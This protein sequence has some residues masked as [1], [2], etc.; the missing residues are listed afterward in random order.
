MLRL[1]EGEVSKSVFGYSIDT[2]LTLYL[3]DCFFVYC[4]VTRMLQLWL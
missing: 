3:N 4:H 1:D 2:R